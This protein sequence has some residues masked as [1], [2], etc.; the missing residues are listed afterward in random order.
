[1]C[2][3]TPC[4][5]ND[6]KNKKSRFVYVTLGICRQCCFISCNYAAIALSSTAFSFPFTVIS[7]KVVMYLPFITLFL[8]VLNLFFVPFRDFQPLLIIGRSSVKQVTG[9]NKY[10][11]LFFP[12]TKALQTVIPDCFCDIIFVFPT[13]PYNYH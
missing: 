5:S 12:L 13:Q 8:I 7:N 2:S 9:F 4:C 11:R 3:K 10:F 1:M 6:L